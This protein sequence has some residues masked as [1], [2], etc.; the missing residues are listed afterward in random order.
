MEHQSSDNNKNKTIDLSDVFALST[1]VW[2]FQADT[3]ERHKLPLPLPPPHEGI[4]SGHERETVSM[5]IKVERSEGR[6][7][8]NV[9][10]LRNHD[11]HILPQIRE[12]DESGALDWRDKEMFFLPHRQPKGLREWRSCICNFDRQ[13]PVDVGL[14]LRFII[15]DSNK[16]LT[17]PEQMTHQSSSSDIDAINYKCLG[18]H[19]LRD[20]DFTDFALVLGCGAELRCHRVIIAQSSSVFRA[21]LKFPESKEAKEGKVYIQDMN[22]ATGKALLEFM[23]TGKSPSLGDVQSIMDLTVAADKYDLE[24]LKDK[25]V[26][27]LESKVVVDNAF[28]LMTFGVAHNLKGVIRKAASSIAKMS[29]DKIENFTS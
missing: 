2:F 25:C 13:S 14:K 4:D 9:R 27:A 26:S 24:A 18:N 28:N 15:L 17:R 22:V 23:Y 12:M 1:V 29:D 6:L 3:T 5:E 7:N 16:L 11:L 21:M 19:L 8:L 10:S 20:E